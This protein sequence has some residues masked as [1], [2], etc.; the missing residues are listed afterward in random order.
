MSGKG[1][2]GKSTI[3]VNLAAGLA[4]LGHK[5]GVVDADVYGPSLA[6]M[7]GVRKSALTVEE[8]GV[9]PAVSSA[10]IKVMSMDL[11]LPEDQTPVVWDGPQADSFTWKGTMEM[12]ALREFLTDTQWGDLDFLLIDL[13]PGTNQFATLHDLLPNLDG[14]VVVSVPSQVS[15]LVVRRSI[16]MINKVLKGRIFGVVENMSAYYCGD[17]DD[18]RPLFGEGQQEYDGVP[19]IGRIAFDPRM[20]Q[21]CDRGVPYVAEHGQTP[22]GVALNQLCEAV[23]RFAEDGDS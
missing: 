17:C 22:V 5:V 8:A 19:V 12:H 7:L 11:L 4:A 6:Q 9:T 20:A 18:L 21:A 2:V 16:T 23:A 14:S 1:G 13:P 15:N 10:G 3:T